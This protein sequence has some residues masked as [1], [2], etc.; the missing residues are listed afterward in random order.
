MDTNV[1]VKGASRLAGVG[2]RHGRRV[3][4][5]TKQIDLDKI[6]GGLEHLALLLAVLPCSPA[7]RPLVRWAQHLDR[8]NQSFAAWL[9]V[10]LREPFRKFVAPD[11]DDHRMR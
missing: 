5:A 9:G 3:L 10:N 7:A 4:A 1:I 8:R 2:E 11:A 6:Y